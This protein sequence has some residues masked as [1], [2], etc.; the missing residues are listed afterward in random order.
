MF[1]VIILYMDIVLFSRVTLLR[2]INKRVENT[3]IDTELALPVCIMLILIFPSKTWAKSAHCTRQNMVKIS[4][5][6]HSV[7]IPFLS[8]QYYI[9]G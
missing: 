8:N 2:Q 4:S 1:Q 7:F 9:W 6:S 3:C 5:H